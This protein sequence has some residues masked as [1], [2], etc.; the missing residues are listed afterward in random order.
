MKKIISSLEVCAK[1]CLPYSTVTHYTNLGLLETVS[2]RGNKRLYEEK[3]VEE[4]LLKI[5]TLASKGYPLLLI[6]DMIFDTSI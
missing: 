5:K 6:R 1:F 4:R 3:E 2:R